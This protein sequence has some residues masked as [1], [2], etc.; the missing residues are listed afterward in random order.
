MEI[1]SPAFK[2]NESIPRKYT[3]QGDNINP[4]LNFLDIPEEAES[5]ALIMDDPDAPNQTFVH[6]VLAD[7]SIVDG[8]EEDSSEGKLGDNSEGEQG[9]TGPCPPSGSH[10]YYFKLYALDTRFDLKNKF[11]KKD[12]EKKMEGH[13]L[14]KAE[15]M[16]RYKKS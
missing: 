13:I 5:L 8:I 4:P 16:G 14:A 7:M 12:L 3:C 15:L 9:Y 10:R 1:T 2:N 11:S 6:W